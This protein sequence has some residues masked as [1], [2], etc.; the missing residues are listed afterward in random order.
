MSADAKPPISED[1]ARA[2][3]RWLIGV[4]ISVVFGLFGVVMA[5][6]SYAEHNKS[7]STPAA[8]SAP[9]PRDTND[10][11]GDAPRKSRKE[12]GRD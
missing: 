5:L 3:R 7:S 6:L 12:R 9:T 11:P 8:R 10:A 1:E 4:I 2:N